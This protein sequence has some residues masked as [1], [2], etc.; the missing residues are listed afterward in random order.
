[1]WDG[2]GSRKVEPSSPRALLVVSR[3]RGIVNQ[4]ELSEV[5]WRSQ[6]SFGLHQIRRTERREPFSEERLEPDVRVRPAAQPDGKVDAVTFQV[7]K[8]YSLKPEIDVR[9]LLREVSKSRQQPLGRKR[10]RN[11][12]CQ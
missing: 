1:M 11:T 12:D 7:R 2:R 6:A 5:P 10:R 9:V 3:Y 4:L 8:R